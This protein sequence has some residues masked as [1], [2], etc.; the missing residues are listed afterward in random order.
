MEDSAR[1]EPFLSCLAILL[2]QV[3]EQVVEQDNTC[4]LKRPSRNVPIHNAS[5]EDETAAVEC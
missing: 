5:F 2:E 4:F 1:R 3:V